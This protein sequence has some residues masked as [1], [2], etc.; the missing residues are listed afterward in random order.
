MKVK[1]FHGEEPNAKVTF[2]ITVD[3]ARELEML[4][5]I[6]KNTYKVQEIANKSDINIYNHE[7]VKHVSDAFYNAIV[8]N[9]SGK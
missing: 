9:Q 1:K 5:D 2:I 3:S 8:T 6:F 4:M 7:E